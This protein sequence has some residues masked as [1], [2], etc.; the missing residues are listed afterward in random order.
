M[1]TDDFDDV[2]DDNFRPLQQLPVPV[3]QD[4]RRYKHNSSGV[5]PGGVL[6]SGPHQLLPLP[7]SIYWWTRAEFSQNRGL[8]K[9]QITPLG[10]LTALPQTLLA[11][12]KGLAAPPQEPHPGLRPHFS[13]LRASGYGPCTVVEPHQH[14]HYMHNSTCK[15]KQTRYL[16]TFQ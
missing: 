12:G 8:L 3:P 5:N 7:W 1:S 6:R 14:L 11:G 2:S 15:Y 10:E 13:A 16:G 4:W 9:R